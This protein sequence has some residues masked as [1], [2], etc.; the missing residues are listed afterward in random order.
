MP[1]EEGGHGF[2]NLAREVQKSGPGALSSARDLYDQSLN[3]SLRD[4]VWTTR[5]VYTPLFE[6]ILKV[7]DERDI[8]RCALEGFLAGNGEVMLWRVWRY[9]LESPQEFNHRTAADFFK[10]INTAAESNIGRHSHWTPL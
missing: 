8:S 2:L 9:M 3:H 7:C 1:G 4:E 10:N 5:D 6:V